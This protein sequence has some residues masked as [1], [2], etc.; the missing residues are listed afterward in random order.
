[1]QLSQ[2]G[3]K[4]L[5]DNE[6]CVLHPYLDGA[7]IP[8]IGIGSTFYPNG[9]HVTMQDPTI[10]Q[11]QAELYAKSEVINVENAVTAMVPAT[12][13]QNQIDS[14]IDF[15]YNE[16]TGALH[17]STLLRLIKA[18]AADPN[19]TAAFKMWDKLH[20]DGNLVFDQ[21]LLDRRIREATLYFTR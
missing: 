8:T 12:L 18:N 3:W 4:F 14:L 17:G 7:D 5:A 2:N 20:V 9:V 10:T 1:M 15:A 21:G 16:G 19:I 11:A 13:N 6:G